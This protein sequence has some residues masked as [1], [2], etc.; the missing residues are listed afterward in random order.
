MS[1]NRISIAYLLSCAATACIGAMVHHRSPQKSWS[2][3]S[4]VIIQLAATSTRSDYL[5]DSPRTRRAQYQ[6]PTKT[7]KNVHGTG[8]ARAH[9]SPLST[10]C[11]LPLCSAP[12]ITG[13]SSDT[14]R[15]FNHA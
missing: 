15:L 7:S 5:S 8:Y 11:I 9:Q 2:S 12:S 4:V 6:Q 10:S 3:L 13:A 14:R 1:Q